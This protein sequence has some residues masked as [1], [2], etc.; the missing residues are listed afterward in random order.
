MK[1]FTALSLVISF[2]GMNCATHERA[3]GIKHEPEQKL[4]IKSI[5]QKTD[6][7]QL[8]GELI[9]V[10]QKSLLLM[11]SGKWT[12]C[13]LTISCVSSRDRSS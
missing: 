10:K 12:K 8:R 13:V 11:E 9:T 7:Q 4:G 5:I 1:K 2:L 6:D 3:K